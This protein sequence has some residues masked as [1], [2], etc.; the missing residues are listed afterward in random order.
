MVEFGPKVWLSGYSFK[1]LSGDV[2]KWLGSG[3]Q[4][5][6]RRF[7]SGRHLQLP[8]KEIVLIMVLLGR[9]WNFTKI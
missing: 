7:N 6:L 5:R 9:W 2:A 8:F 3:L 1:G 4:N